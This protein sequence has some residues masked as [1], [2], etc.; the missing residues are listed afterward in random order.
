MPYGLELDVDDRI[1]RVRLHGL[2][3]DADLVTADDELR[4]HPDFEADFDQFVDVSAATQEEI[5]AGMLRELAARPPLFGAES[6]RAVVVRTDLGYGL[7]RIFQARRG[8]AA[9]TAARECRLRAGCNEFGRRRDGNL[10]SQREVTMRIAGAAAA[11]SASFWLM[12]PGCAI[13]ST[14]ASMAARLVPGST[15]STG[16]SPCI[17]TSCAPSSRARD[18]NPAIEAGGTWVISTAGIALI[19]L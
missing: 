7:A 11:S 1:V 12:N 18:T 9:G 16:L 17:T 10:R 8:D 19:D 14:P 6:R 2:I 15:G 3:T 13:M 4:A 5:T